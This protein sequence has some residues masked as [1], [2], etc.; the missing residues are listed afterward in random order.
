MEYAVVRVPKSGSEYSE[1]AYTVVKKPGVPF[2]AA[3]IDLHHT[4]ERGTPE[5]EQIAGQVAETFHDGFVRGQGSDRFGMAFRSADTLM[6][7]Q[8]PDYG[9]VV[10]AVSISGTNLRLMHLGDTRLYATDWSESG[11][12][13]LTD[14]HVASSI[15]ELQRMEDALNSGKFQVRVSV[16]RGHVVHRLYRK[17]FFGWA[18]EG[19]QPTR[20]LGDFRFRPALTPKPDSVTICL[21]RLPTGTIFALCTDGARRSVERAY[22]KIRG[23]A[24]MTPVSAMAAMVS[25]G[26]TFH[27]NDD[28]TVILF[29][30]N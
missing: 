9:A 15:S 23:Q 30:A 10:T 19:L 22:T 24:P 18:K 2:M 27:H 11:F 16:E 13:I 6:I 3:V 17:I 28:A 25:Q 5:A 14:D 4:G 21:R 20:G 1:D 26:L 29:R 7:E 12:Q 8:F